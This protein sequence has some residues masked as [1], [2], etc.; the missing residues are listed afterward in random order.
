MRCSRDVGALLR[1]PSRHSGRKDTADVGW[2]KPLASPATRGW[3]T[4]PALR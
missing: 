3:D 4:L 1:H 2:G